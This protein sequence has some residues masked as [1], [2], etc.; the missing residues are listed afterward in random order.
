MTF[1]KGQV[2][3]VKVEIRQLKML[4]SLVVN[5]IDRRLFLDH[6]YFAMGFFSGVVEPSLPQ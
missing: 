5:A 4:I 2:S 1:P 6:E 3:V